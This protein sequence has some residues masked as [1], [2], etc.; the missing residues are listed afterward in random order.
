MQGLLVK[1]Q[2]RVLL[3]SLKYKAFFL[4]SVVSRSQL[5]MFFFKFAFHVLSKSKL[6]FLINTNFAIHLYM[7]QPILNENL[8][9]FISYVKSPKSHNSYFLSSY[10]HVYFILTRT[11]KG[12]HKTQVV[13]ISFV[14]THTF[15]PTVS[16]FGL[17]MHTGRLKEKEPVFYFSLC[18]SVIICSLSVG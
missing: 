18:F 14:N 10:M 1:R 13:F 16:T 11:A 5:T 2:E 6:N 7:V 15:L 9:A 17:I 12:L 8:R 4:I 3:K